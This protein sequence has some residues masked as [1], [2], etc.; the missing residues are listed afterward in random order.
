MMGEGGE[1]KDD[2]PKGRGTNGG[3]NCYS[4]SP[5]RSVYS[6]FPS[7]LFP[8]FSSYLSSVSMGFNV[9]VFVCISFGM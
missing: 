2:I 5:I 6:P 9:R 3:R 7:V 8:F 4:V 1:R